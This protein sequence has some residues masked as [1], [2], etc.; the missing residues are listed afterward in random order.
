MPFRP[1]P[2]LDIDQRDSTRL[3]PWAIIFRPSGLPNHDFRRA[4]GLDIHNWGI[5]GTVNA[6][7]DDSERHSSERSDAGNSIVQEVFAFVKR[8]L[9]EAQRRKSA[10]SGERGAGK[11]AAGPCPRLST[12]SIPERDSSRYW[13]LTSG[14]PVIQSGAMRVERPWFRH[15]EGLIGMWRSHNLCEIVHLSNW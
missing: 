7:R 3:T 2:G 15:P 10:A 5:L 12:Q 6:I 13:R 1:V 8:N 9:S 11:G 4:P 14:L